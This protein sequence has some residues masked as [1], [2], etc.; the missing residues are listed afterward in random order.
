MAAIFNEILKI[1]ISL[2]LYLDLRVEIQI[3][4]VH[5]NG[6][7]SLQFVFVPPV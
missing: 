6:T 2:A 4:M 5:F 3:W 1:C 7:R